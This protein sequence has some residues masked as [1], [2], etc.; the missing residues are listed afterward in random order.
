VS[1][2]ALTGAN[3]A[4]ET[5]TYGSLAVGSGFLMLAGGIIAF[6]AS[7]YIKAHPLYFRVSSGTI[8]MGYKF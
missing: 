2:I 6:D 1:S 3:T 4:N 5:H 7:T 8:A